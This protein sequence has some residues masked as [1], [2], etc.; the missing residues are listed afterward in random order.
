V[1]TA[2]IP[3]AV[4]SEEALKK[5]EEYIEAERARPIVSRLAGQRW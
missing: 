3:S 5:A 2:E 1:S 4:V